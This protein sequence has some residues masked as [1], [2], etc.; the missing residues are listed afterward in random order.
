MEFSAEKWVIDGLVNIM[1]IKCQ[2]W[3]F[4]TLHA[5][6][7]NSNDDDDTEEEVDRVSDYVYVHT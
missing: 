5:K 2:F 3:Y 4:S 1:H 7:S 6:L